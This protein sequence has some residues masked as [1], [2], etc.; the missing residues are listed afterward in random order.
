MYHKM[1]IMSE[2]D[3]VCARES[4]NAH[5]SILELLFKLSEDLMNLATLGTVVGLVVAT[6]ETG[7]GHGVLC[8]VKWL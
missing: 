4:A 1:H 7:A 8:Q 2:S 3:L 5:E 6:V